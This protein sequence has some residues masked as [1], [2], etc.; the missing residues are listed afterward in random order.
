M[1]PPHGRPKE[2]SLPASLALREERSVEGSAGAT[3][4]LGVDPRTSACGAP[5]RV[6]N[7]ALGGKARSAKGVHICPP[8]GRPKEGSLPASLRQHEKPSLGASAGATIRLGV[9]P[10][11][12]NTRGA[13]RRVANIALGG[14]AR[15]AKGAQ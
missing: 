5:R 12:M 13:P 4:R 8:H 9:D 14:K 10:R 15:S 1:S 3:I 6:A 7:I 2:G 11:A